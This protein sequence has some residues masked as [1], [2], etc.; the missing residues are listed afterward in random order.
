MESIRP[1]MNTSR[2]DHEVLHVRDARPEDIPALTTIKGVDTEAC[3]RDRIRD[4]QSPG[5]RYLVLQ[6][7]KDVIGFACL[8][9]QRPSS[10]SDAD[11]PEHLPQMVDLEIEETCRNRGYGAYLIQS[12]ERLAHEAG[13]NQFYLCVEPMDNPR[14]Y[15]LYRRLGYYPLQQTPYWK[16]RSF[17]DSS[18]I[19]H[20]GEDLVVDMVKPLVPRPR[21]E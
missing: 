9:F 18:G 10:W 3:H 5:F 8:V 6:K 1:S 2:F 20:H 4:A 11:D 7:G 16:A 13:F 19:F 15:A 14:A 17:T 12:L 21:D